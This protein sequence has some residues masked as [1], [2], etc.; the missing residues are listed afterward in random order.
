VTAA[1]PPHYVFGYGVASLA[2]FVLILGLAL[3]FGV[4][5]YFWG[6]IWGVAIY[7]ALWIVPLVAYWSY[8]LFR[9]NY[10][11]EENR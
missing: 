10:N 2:F 1:K 6:G 4:A 5:S 8:L 7:G 3:G 9:Q 11:Y